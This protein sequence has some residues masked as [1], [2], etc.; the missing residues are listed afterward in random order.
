MRMVPITIRVDELQFIPVVRLLR[1]TPGVLVDFDLDALT[2]PK[3]TNGNSNAAVP[4]SG[5]RAKATPL[6]QTLVAFLGDGSK[7]ID[8][9]RQ[10]AVKHGFSAMS[11]PDKLTKLREMGFVQQTEGRGM[12]ELTP[13]A[14]NKMQEAMSTITPVPLALPPPAGDAMKRSAPREIVMKFLREAGGKLPRLKLLS[15]CQEAGLTDRAP[16]NA[17]YNLRSD[18]MI[19]PIGAKGVPAGIIE[20]T[21]KGAAQ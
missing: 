15:L 21:P 3:K 18:K 6:A 10:E 1:A 17:V 16:A 7:H 19:K 5:E 9:L 12:Y 14:M 4:E 20:L 13:S 11:V 2:R 8:D